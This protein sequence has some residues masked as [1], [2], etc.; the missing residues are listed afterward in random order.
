[1]LLK[2]I[3]IKTHLKDPTNC[4]IICDEDTKETIVIDPAGEVN[5]IVE[6]LDILQAK[7][8]YIVITH[9]HGDHV[10]GVNELVE[11]KGGTILIHRICKNNI[12]NQNIMLTEYIGMPEVILKDVRIVD[13]DDLLHVGNTEIKVIHTPGHTSGG[14]SLYCKEH[15]MLF[16]G[17]TLFRGTWGRTDLPTGSIKDIMNS[18]VNKLLVLPDDT[19]VYPGHGLPTSIKEEKPIYLKLEPRSI[20]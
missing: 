1:M 13:E 11:K 18:I 15:K 9:C 19:I 4:Y 12:N 7:L 8:K 5:K 3:K 10:G 14:I 17:D 20:I 2:R 6:M 16:S